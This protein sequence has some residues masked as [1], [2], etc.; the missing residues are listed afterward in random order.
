MPRLALP[1]FAAALLAASSFFMLPQAV[2]AAS[3]DCAKTDLA[4]D[5]T[6]ICKDLSLNDIDVRVATTFDLLA[7][8]M[9][10]GNRDMLRDEQ[11][12]W[13][14]TRQACDDDVACIR[15]AYER[16]MTQLDE[17]YKTLI[18]PM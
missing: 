16:R 15:N 14:K 7:G 5:E 18:K 9:P 6:A 4:A 10:M 17:A 11:L 8:L 2:R 3:F 1:A 12:A 13:L